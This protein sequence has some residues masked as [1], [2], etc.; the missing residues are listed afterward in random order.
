M[1]DHRDTKLSVPY[2]DDTMMI[3][4]LYFPRFKVS[5][6]NNLFKI[7]GGWEEYD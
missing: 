4:V 2:P 7:L 3:L 5:P 6:K 1:R